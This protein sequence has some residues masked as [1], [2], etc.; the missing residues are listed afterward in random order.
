[1]RLRKNQ[2]QLVTGIDIGST[3]IRVAAGHVTE[4]AGRPLIQIMGGVEVPAGGVHRGMITSIEET[5]SS[6]SNALERMERLLGVPIEHAWIGISNAQIATQE[7][8]GVVAVAKSNGEIGIDDVERSIEAARTVAPPVN[9]E[10]LHVLPRN[11]SVDGQTGIKDPAGMTGIRLE[12]DTKIIHGLS[13]HIKNLTK[14]VYRTG[15]EI[16]DLVLSILAAGDVVTT[17]RQKELGTAVVNIGGSTTSMVVYLDGDITHVATFPIGSEHITNDIAIG[18]RTSIDVAE[19]VKIDYGNCIRRD[20]AKKEKIDLFDIGSDAHEEISKSY[21]AEIISAR[22]AEI[23]E[24][25]QKEFLVAGAAGLLPAGVMMTGGGAKLSGLVPFAK[26]ALNLPVSL[27]YPVD[28][29]SI[30]QHIQDVSFSTAVG[31]VKWGAQ[32]HMSAEKH[33]GGWLSGNAFVGKVKEFAKS[34]MP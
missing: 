29:Q 22:V 30:S 17:P 15:I 18:L 28:I 34:L 2:T 10:T 23:L 32:L 26:D 21:I 24:R 31:L 33:H 7:S 4:S 11:F 9:Y 13:S 20:A 27:G 1:M 3:A 8:K 14:A 5:V 19:R 6:L 25:V 16:D 12:A